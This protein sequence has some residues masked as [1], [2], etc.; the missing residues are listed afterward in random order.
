MYYANRNKYFLKINLDCMPFK[1]A[2]AKCI[3]ALALATCQYSITVGKLSNAIRDGAKHPG[4]SKR[5]ACALSK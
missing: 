5:K 3:Y 1:I 4:H 2:R